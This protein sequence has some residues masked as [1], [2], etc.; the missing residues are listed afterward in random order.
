MRVLNVENSTTSAIL[1]LYS[2]VAE[3]LVILSDA[4]RDVAEDLFGE[5]LKNSDLKIYSTIFLYTQL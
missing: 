5:E 3:L 1:F 2:T 4:R